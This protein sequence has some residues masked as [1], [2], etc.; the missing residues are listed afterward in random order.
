MS[1]RRL[2]DYEFDEPA[3]TIDVPTERGKSHVSLGVFTPEDYEDTWLVVQSP[4]KRKKEQSMARKLTERFID[5][6][7]TVEAAF[8][9]K[10]GTKS[11]DKVWERI[12]RVK[13]RHR[14]VS[15]TYQ[16]KR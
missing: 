5:E 1:N 15:G 8:H 10:G 6:L 2:A 14:R 13:Q 11:I 4:A 3:H 7:T 16:I 9:K 12:G